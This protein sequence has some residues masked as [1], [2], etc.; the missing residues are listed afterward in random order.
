MKSHIWKKKAVLLMIGIILSLT[1]CQGAEKKEDGVPGWCMEDLR[2]YDYEK[3][4]VI[5]AGQKLEIEL[6]RGWQTYRGVMLGDDAKEA[7]SKYSLK[8]FEFNFSTL[9]SPKEADEIAKKLDEK[10]EALSPEEMLEYIEE[11]PDFGGR[12]L[13]SVDVYLKDGKFYTMS[14]LEDEED[15]QYQFWYRFYI[16]N[17]KIDD[18]LI[19]YH[20]K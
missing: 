10:Y 13:Y 14:E 9:N 7:L 12:L 15:Y 3:K 18:I 19:R 8:D 17:G 20:A 4:P 6:K 5:K 1:G 2:F 11:V 16:L